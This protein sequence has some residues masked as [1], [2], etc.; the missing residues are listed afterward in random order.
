MERRR[1]RESNHSVPFINFC[2]TYYNVTLNMQVL[3]SL[4]VNPSSKK[5]R[6]VV[7]IFPLR[8][9]GHST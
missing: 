5:V 8:R 2:T 9:L 1:E 6:K 7:D 3:R 4:E